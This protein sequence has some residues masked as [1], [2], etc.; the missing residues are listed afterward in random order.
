MIPRMTAT[1]TSAC[2]FF[3]LFAVL[4]Q[5]PLAV[6]GAT[7]RSGETMQIGAAVLAS[8][9]AGAYRAAGASTVSLT[10]DVA[11]VC[12]AYQPFCNSI[13]IT[14]LSIMS[15]K[16]SGEEQPTQRVGHSMLRVSS[17][18]FILF[19]GERVASNCQ[20][21]A[22]A[23]CRTEFTDETWILTNSIDTTGEIT[24]RK[25]PKIGAWPSGRAL[26]KAA[27][28]LD[29][30]KMIIAGGNNSTFYGMHMKEVWVLDIAK[31]TWTNPAKLHFPAYMEGTNK[32]V[33][34][35]MEGTNKHAFATGTALVGNRANDPQ[36]YE[37]LVALVYRSCYL[38]IDGGADEPP[39]TD[40]VACPDSMDDTYLC[41][42]MPMV[43]VLNL[44]TYKWTHIKTGAYFRA[45]S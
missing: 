30:S 19:G 31:G 37:G 7:S 38:S 15:L 3:C 25:L 39:S 27:V 41:D 20:S 2:A 33:S 21:Q 32:N 29:G 36:V 12:G 40:R 44:E 10:Q 11:I 24:W 43:H 35:Y 5:L 23:S 45:L 9:P 22:S 6:T 17:D 14:H 18:T 8:N 26:H 42:N 13:D 16:F 4:L 34:A 28:S 1:W